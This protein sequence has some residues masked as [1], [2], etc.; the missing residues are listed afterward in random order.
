M[1]DKNHRLMIEGNAIYEI[2]LECVRKKEK[3][4][5]EKNHQKKGKFPGRGSMAKGTH[6]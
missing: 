5:A 2:D 6:H 3:E 4:E 1:K